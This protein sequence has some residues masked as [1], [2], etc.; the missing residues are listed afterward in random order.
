MHNDFIM[1]TPVPA[2][3]APVP[4]EAPEQPPAP[5]Q[6]VK[7]LTGRLSEME[8]SYRELS[9]S[10]KARDKEM[11]QQLELLNTTL[12]D[13]FSK[14]APVPDASGEGK[15]DDNFWSDY[16]NGNQ[17]QPQGRA[18]QA[19]A[20]TQPTEASMEPKK[21]RNIAREEFRN[22][23]QKANDDILAQQNEMQQLSTTFQE[24][25]THLHHAAPQV[26]K[27]YN[28][29]DKA[30]PN[31][32]PT[33]KFQIAIEEAESMFPRQDPVQNPVGFSSG[34]QSR[35]YV[36]VQRQPQTLS[37]MPVRTQAT[38]QQALENYMSERATA[39]KNRK[40]N[41]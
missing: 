29:V 27:L 28:M 21:V 26:Q 31:L 36:G 4:T 37:E 20:S 10:S 40:L 23:A 9:K 2:K 15:K 32:S 16:I 8:K 3:P 24:N 39:S 34:G 18:Q 11:K 19:Q 22:L 12:Q 7:E 17:Q 33:Q 13:Q 6:D 35:P 14:T 38:Q 1:S 25:Y 30:N 41:F 5:G